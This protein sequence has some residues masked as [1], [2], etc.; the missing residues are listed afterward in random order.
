[1][2]SGRCSVSLPDRRGGLTPTV[3]VSSLFFRYCILITVLCPGIC[4][5]WTGPRPSDLQNA[6]SLPSVSIPRLEHAPALEDFLS[7]RPEGE[8]ASRM[9]KVTG[10]V[11]RNP[12]DG[13]PASQPTE[14]YLGY[15]DKN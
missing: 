14:A 15:D 7:M 6:V 2:Q 1:Y 4:L 13:E 9:K 12:H 8:I 11:Q 3:E 10:F 5:A